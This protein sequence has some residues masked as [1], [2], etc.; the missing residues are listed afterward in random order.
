MR[1]LVFTIASALSLLLGLAAATLWVRSYWRTD[2]VSYFMACNPG[3]ISIGCKSP[4]VSIRRAA[5]WKS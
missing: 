1:R 3:L 5:A 2:E 4:S